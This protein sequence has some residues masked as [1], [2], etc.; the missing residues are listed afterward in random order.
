MALNL[1][2]CVKCN[3]YNIREVCVS[4]GGKAVNPKPPKYSV[5]DRYAKYRRQAKEEEE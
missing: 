2:R 4:C 5:E 3:R 1:L